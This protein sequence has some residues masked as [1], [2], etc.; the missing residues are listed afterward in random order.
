MPK[1]YLFDKIVIYDEYSDIQYF[2]SKQQD[3]LFNKLVTPK[4]R[5]ITVL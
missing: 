2:N 1:R 5:L 3:L 4:Y